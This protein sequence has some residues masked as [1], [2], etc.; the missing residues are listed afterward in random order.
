MIINDTQIF[1]QIRSDGRLVNEMRR[2]EVNCEIIDN[3]GVIHLNH[4]ETHVTGTLREP[5]DKSNLSFLINF[6]GGTRNEG[7]SDRR[8]YEL[9][10]SLYEVFKNVVLPGPS[11]CLDLIVKQDNGG[12][13]SAL[14]NTATLV[15]CYHGVAM[16]DM[17]VS[18][19]SGKVLDLSYTEQ[20]REFAMTLAYLPKRNKISYLN[21]EG[22]AHKKLY[23]NALENGVKGCL[24][25]CDY[26]ENILRSINR[27]ESTDKN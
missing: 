26:F 25:L 7:F 12:L 13:L 17:C 20:N 18:I 10:T 24:F 11:I 21:S 16:I 15:M 1:S 9:R 27:P 8:L 23:N 6:Y 14:I 3:N 2:I 4:G 19:T 22:K 5:K